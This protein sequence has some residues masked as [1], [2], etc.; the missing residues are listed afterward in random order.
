MD[1]LEDLRMSLLNFNFVV[2]YIIH[3][4]LA[5][6]KVEMKLQKIYLTYYSLL[7]VQDLWRVHYRILSIIFLKEFIELNVNSDQMLKN[8]RLVFSDIQAL[9]MI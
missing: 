5:L 9:K 8:V 4:I 3:K 1:L 6:I 2:I 7:T